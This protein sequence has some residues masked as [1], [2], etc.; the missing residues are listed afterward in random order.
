MKKNILT[1]RYL[2]YLFLSIKGGIADAIVALNFKNTPVH[3][4]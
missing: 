4:N 3:T 1:L 2:D